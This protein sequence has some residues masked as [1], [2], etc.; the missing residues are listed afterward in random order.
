MPQVP[1]VCE[2]W[3]VFVL[4][5]CMYLCLNSFSNV[6][7]TQTQHTGDPTTDFSIVPINKYAM[8]KGNAVQPRY[9]ITIHQQPERARLCS[10]KE[11]NETSES[12]FHGMANIDLLQ[13]HCPVYILTDSR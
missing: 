12:N 4:R 1:H 11:E 5:L 9:Q 13:L 8:W 7:Y 3:A 2:M 10:F 6:V